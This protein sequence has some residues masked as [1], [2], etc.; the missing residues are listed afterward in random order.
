MKRSERHRIKKDEFSTFMVSFIKALSPYWK[1]IAVT[2]TAVIVILIVGFS[3]KA[4]VSSKI[5]KAN[6]LLGRY[7]NSGKKVDLAKYPVPFPQ[8][9]AILKAEKLADEDKYDE[10]IK[11]LKGVQPKGIMREYIYFM[12]GELLS[13][14]GDC[15]GAIKVWQKVSSDAKDFPYDALLA[16]MGRCQFRLGKIKE[17]RAT[18]NQIISLFP[19][20]PYVKEAKYK[21]GKKG[22]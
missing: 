20:S 5:K 17:A 2:I 1:E 11:V 19:N 16:H 7:I 8:I 6:Y 22:G 9:E 21:T 4:Y 15:E 14:K 12:E 3:Y 10:A 13:E 18:Y